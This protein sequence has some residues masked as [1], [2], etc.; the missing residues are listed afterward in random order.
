MAA[1][2]WSTLSSHSRSRKLVSAVSAGTS[3]ETVPPTTSPLEPLEYGVNASGVRACVVTVEA[4]SAQTLSG[5]GTLDLYVWD[6]GV[7]AWMPVYSSDG[8]QVQYAVSASAVRR[9]TFYAVVFDARGGFFAFVPNG[10]TTS[11]GTT[12]SVYH[13]CSLVYAP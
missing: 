11:G 5:A 12:V 1:G 3:T 13:T 6:L 7:G 4:A 9:M 2:T 8:T 10:I